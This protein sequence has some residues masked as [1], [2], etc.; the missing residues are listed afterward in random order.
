MAVA[1]IIIML[2]PAPINKFFPSKEAFTNRTFPYMVATY[3]YA[4]RNSIILTYIKLNKYN[5]VI[6]DFS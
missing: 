6:P 1:G 5:N 3:L 2:T 4:R